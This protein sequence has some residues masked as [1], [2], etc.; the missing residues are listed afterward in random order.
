MQI[1]VVSDFW[2]YCTFWV[3]K[4]FRKVVF[5]YLYR[6]F[7]LISGT[8]KNWCYSSDNY[9]HRSFCLLSN[10]LAMKVALC[11]IHWI[12]MVTFQWLLSQFRKQLFGGGKVFKS[13]W[14]HVWKVTPF[15]L[16]H[17]V[18]SS[19]KTFCKVC[20]QQGSSLMIYLFR[21]F[22]L[23]WRNKGPCEFVNVFRWDFSR[24]VSAFPQTCLAMALEFHQLAV[25]R[26]A[27]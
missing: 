10:F 24:T 17:N 27:R 7:R 5:L 23:K 3:V 2:G 4:L 21:Y 13:F 19:C 16:V 26:A 14:T 12:F 8:T 22:K 15:H 6:P 20:A 11:T 9:T 18:H 1:F 25:L